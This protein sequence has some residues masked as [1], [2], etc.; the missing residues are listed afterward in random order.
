V[1]AVSIVSGSIAGKFSD[2]RTGRWIPI[3]LPV[4][5]TL[6]L[7]SPT[8][9][10][11]IGAGFSAGVAIKNIQHSI[12]RKGRYVTGEDFTLSG[13]VEKVFPGIHGRKNLIV[14]VTEILSRQQVDV[15]FK[16]H[17]TITDK[18]DPV[19]GTRL[20]L[21]AVLKH[22]SN[23]GKDGPFIWGRLAGDC[24]ISHEGSFFS[25]SETRRR[26]GDYLN[27]QQ[28]P[29]AGLFAAISLGQRWRVARSLG[30]IM[31]RTGIYHLMAI[32]GVHLVSAFV[33][34]LLIVRLLM[35]GF[36]VDRV[37]WKN[38]WPLGGGY[39][40][41]CVYLS[42]TGLSTS[43]LRAGVFVLLIWA[44]TLASRYPDPL[45]VL[46]WCPIFIISNNQSCQPD[47]A[48]LLSASAVAGI[49]VT[50]RN[51]LPMISGCF[52]VTMGA[53][54]FTL[55]L[56]V[57][58]TGGIPVL[59]PVCNAVFGIIFGLVLIPVAVFIDL[60]A[61]F[62]WSVWEPLIGVWI[63]LARPVLSILDLVSNL[64]FVFLILSEA[65]CFLVTLICLA[66]I[67]AWAKRGYGLGTGLAL[68]LIIVV[69]A[70]AFEQTRTILPT[71]VT[72]LC[73]PRVGQ[74]DA[75]ILRY[76]DHIIVIDCA[77]PAS[78]G[79]STPVE[80]T[81]VKMGVRK[82]DGLFLTHAHPDHV[83]G[84]PNLA[85]RWKIGV[86]Y[87]PE[88]EKDPGRW[89]V[90]LDSLPT[91]TNV[92]SLRK[93]ESIS[94]G[95]FDFLVLGP[96]REWVKERGENAGSL[97]LYVRGEGVYALFTGDA[98]WEQ[99]C[100]SL[101]HLTRL[102]L[103]KI[104]HHGSKQ[105]FPPAQ[106]KSIMSRLQKS[107]E[108]TAVFP[109][110]PPGNEGLPAREVVQWFEKQGIRCLFTGEGAGVV[111]KYRK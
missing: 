40:I 76:E 32:S 36:R 8:L 22:L 64:P 18:E 82:I 93:G 99:V 100:L 44:G 45:S 31:R 15:R 107:G 54:L 84:F 63:H 11:L 48:L 69:T 89:S 4:T 94:I 66:A 38:L 96:A 34:P 80:R 74:A 20:R 41:I 68:F 37:G 19:T 110:P 56:S 67:V 65:G 43:A 97:Q 111:M 103:F 106:L 81:L 12:N 62:P 98:Q 24:L 50:S 49:I 7:F 91:G 95:S 51:P 25:L 6:A 79:R 28:D 102:D 58:C 109:S 55:P 72:V 21:R 35:A 90:I 78:P 105:G 92:V 59:A 57:W 16:L 108:M 71:G 42:L 60:L 27:G 87:L 101:E 52:R 5:G 30:N 46:G 2:E 23:G 73:F 61:C 26:L 33:F 1:L 47:L 10:G 17:L 3:S 13:R 86:L 14:N 53:V 88:I 29:A 9:V 70:G 75:A 77:A 85:Q 83:G 39:M 104:P